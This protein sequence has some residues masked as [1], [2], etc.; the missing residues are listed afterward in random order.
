[1]AA[2]LP[3]R[4]GTP[5]HP[6]PAAPPAQRTF[7]SSPETARAAREYVREVVNLADPPF[8]LDRVSDLQLVTSELVTN[9]VRYGTEPGD[10]I[11]VTVSTGPRH[12]RVEVHDPTRRRPR[13]RPDSDE[14]ARG[15]GLF[16]VE[17]LA[18]SWGVDDR[19]MGKVV[20]AVI[21]W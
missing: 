16:V 2:M 7:G 9:A 4:L 15:R 13:R 21:S 12:V 6:A 5:L 1:M 20:W 11:L 18:R 14:R 19:P 8:A 10:S 17:A 3:Q